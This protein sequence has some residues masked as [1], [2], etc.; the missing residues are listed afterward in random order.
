MLDSEAG[1]ASAGVALGRV[2]AE[3]GTTTLVRGAC[4][5][6]CSIAFAGGRTRLL[7][8]GGRL[9]FQRPTTAASA[10]TGAG[11][12]MRATADFLATRGIRQDFVQD[13]LARDERQPWLPPPLTLFEAG[14]ISGIIIHGET[15]D[16][17]AYPA[18]AVQA[19]VDDTGALPPFQA[20][21][22]LDPAAF[23]AS[24]LRLRQLL[25]REGTGDPDADA[26]R[27][28]VRTELHDAALRALP[29]TSDAAAARYLKAD[30]DQLRVLRNS[31]PEVCRAL[32]YPQFG[33]A[34]G[35]LS[36]FLTEDTERAYRD[37]LQAVLVD[38]QSGDKR[39]PRDP[40]SAADRQQVLSAVLGRYP[41]V[42][43]SGIS[44][45]EE[46]RALDALSVCAFHI[47][48]R[49]DI[50]A[51]PPPRDGATLRRMTAEVLGH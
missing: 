2:L 7:G 41:P 9:T 3:Q 20:L 15:L 37:A 26:Y 46:F 35:D 23:D 25:M 16:R 1:R 18:A 40:Q 32:L 11:D 13:A 28:A 29:L 38:A 14:V 49:E 19:I 8:F 33:V 5:G 4:G 43:S 48:L 17:Q 24:Q 6:P 44:R 30:L 22:A 42:F 21:K 51:L 10:A 45:P 31:A 27:H 39:P 50:L 12:L 34:A 47:S 36:A